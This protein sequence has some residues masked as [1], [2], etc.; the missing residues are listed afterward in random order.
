[1]RDQAVEDIVEAELRTALERAEK[2]KLKR[3]RE[4][5]EFLRRPGIRRVVI[6]DRPERSWG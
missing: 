1:M 6:A 3:Q 5:A 4:R 2:A